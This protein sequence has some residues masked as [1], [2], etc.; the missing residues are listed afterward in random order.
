VLHILNIPALKASP[1]RV[2]TERVFV[3]F[4]SPNGQDGVRGNAV[5]LHLRS[6][7]FEL[8]D[9]FQADVRIIPRLDLNQFLPKSFLI[10]YL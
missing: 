10:H 3:A 2:Y 5:D 6:A 1:K 9:V 8:T 4:L 7:R